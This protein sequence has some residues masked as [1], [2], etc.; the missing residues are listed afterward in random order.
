MN[1]SNQ[2]HI[3]E[4]LHTPLHIIR[5]IFRTPPSWP[6]MADGFHV[7]TGAFGYSGRWI[8][9]LLLDQGI[10]VKTLTN[11]IGRDDPFDGRVEVMPIDFENTDSL[12]E[13]LRGAEVLYNTYWV[14]Y[15]KKS[16]GY[17]HSLA[18]RNCSI[19]FDAALEAGVGRV[20]HFSVSRPEDAPGW[21]YFQGKVEAERALRESGNSYAIVRPTLLFG[22]RRNVLVNNMAWLI[23]SFPVFGLFGR[24]NYPIQPV[25]VEDVAR[26][27]IGAGMK[28]EDITMDVAGPETYTY[29]EFVRAIARGMGVSRLII[30]VP[31]AIGWLAGRLFGIFLKDDVITMAEIRGLMQGLMASEE[32][33]RGKLLFSEWVSENGDSLGLKY[34]NDLRERRYSSPNDEFN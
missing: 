9:K 24:G 13:S 2:E 19:L 15:N 6:G 23:R 1:P 10:R 16:E 29:K 8:A 12:V 32:E 21:T 33:P 20:V 31:P 18:A 30:P 17:D 34:H 3:R 7:V 27:A 25:H 5:G 22:G 26:V 14:R 11:A 4:P 28:N